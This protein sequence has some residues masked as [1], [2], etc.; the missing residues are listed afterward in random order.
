METD[1]RIY[2]A[3][4]RGLV[5]SAC[6]R[7]LRAAGYTRI[8]EKARAELDLQDQVAVRRFYAETRPE[9]VIDAAAKVGG[10]AA[11]STYPVEFLLQNLA[12]Q[13]NLIQGAYEGGVKKFLFLGSSCIYPKFAEQPIRESSLLTGELESSNE[14][15]AIAKIAGVKLC[16]AYRREY[17]ASFCSAMP[18]NL[19]GINDNFNLLTSHVLPALIRRFHEAKV[20]RDP[21]VTCWGTG[22]PRRE[23]LFADDCAEACVFLLRNYDSG[24]IINVGTGEDL[25]IREIA[26]LVKE[27]VGYEGEILWDPTQPDGTPRK[28][29]DVQRI[30]RLGWKARTSLEE[31]VRITYQWWVNRSG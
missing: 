10:I 30:N 21:A 25:S 13:N 19:Y 11:N 29:M 16:Q 7:A 3:G 27:I 31:G 5:G 17:G 22:S 8:I 26:S 4:H 9:Y 2:V 12:I 18:T 14:A 23:L 28:V 24:E 1:A 6:V 15:Y 20:A